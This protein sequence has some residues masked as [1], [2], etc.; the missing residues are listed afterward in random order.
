VDGRDQH[1]SSAKL[2]ADGALLA[3]VRLG[4]A[5]Q[6]VEARG[7]GAYPDVCRLY[8]RAVAL[9][10]APDGR[11]YVL[12]VFRVAGGQRHDWVLHGSANEDMRLSTS[13]SAA[14]FQ[15]NLL[16][17]AVPFRPWKNEYGRNL[18]DG[19]NNSYGLFRDLQRAPGGRAWSARMECDGGVG[20]QTTVLG[21]AGTEVFLGRIPS[22][23]RAREDS[24]RVNDFWMPALLARREGKDL[25]STFA[26]VHQA[27]AAYDEPYDVTP[28]AV[29]STDPLAVG[30]VVR[31][32]GFTDYHL[33]GSEPD[34]ELR[35]VNPPIRAKGRYALVRAIARR[36]ACLGVAD[37]S[38]LE[39]QGI[40]LPV[41][42]GASGEVLSVRN[43]EA[44]DAEHALVV[45]ASL[46]ARQGL[47]DERVVVRFGDGMTYGLPVK[48][49]RR[50]GTASVIVLHRRP[51]FRVSADG[52]Q[53][54]QTHWPR[55]T[56]IGRPS[57]H[58]A[59]SAFQGADVP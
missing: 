7:E 24:S 55:R 18:L 50:E 40:S 11:A 15:P 56:S 54:E 49:I 57:F 2:P 16:P 42:Q 38:A 43:Q 20:V 34:S 17:G 5:V 1:T 30:L 10:A 12:D 58:L 47:P 25:Q 26:A 23:R 29:E 41:L 53:T 59:P 6:Y 19:V 28:L 52:R 36:S 37:G 8:R 13:L 51:G 21:Q 27:Y 46:P 14:D 4:K 45:S 44:G 3:S 39:Y 22:V 48:E 33:C 35:A 31:G 32:K 9:V